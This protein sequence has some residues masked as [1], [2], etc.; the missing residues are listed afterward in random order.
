MI[1]CEFHEMKILYDG[2]R[3]IKETSYCKIDDYRNNYHVDK[4]G[5]EKLHCNGLECDCPNDYL[6]KLHR[7]LKP[8]YKT[9]K[10]D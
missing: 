2:D 6:L 9:I 7:I 8:I 4:I 3:R 5:Y 1:S 10:F